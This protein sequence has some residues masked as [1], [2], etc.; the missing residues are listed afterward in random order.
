MQ[1]DQVIG[2]CINKLGAQG[3]NVTRTAWLANDGDQSTPCITIDSQCGSSQEAT[4][5]ATSLIAAGMVILSA[6]LLGTGA[7]TSMACGIGD[8]IDMSDVALVG[9]GP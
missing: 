5:L 8:A 6:I 9:C 1:V 3:M 2:G 4:T 7:F